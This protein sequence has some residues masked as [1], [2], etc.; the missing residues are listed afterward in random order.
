M[1]N[2]YGPDLHIHVHV[3]ACN[4]YCIH[5]C[6]QYMTECTMHIHMYMLTGKYG[7]QPGII[8]P[9]ERLTNDQ[10]KEEL[11][12]RELYD[13]GSTKA[14]TRQSLNEA[15]R[16]VQRVPSL[17]LNSPVENIRT[18]NLE[19]Y[20]ILECEPLHNLKGHL[21][22]VFAILPTILGKELAASCK[23][24]LNI[25]LFQK[26]TKRGFDCRLTAIHLLSLLK[27]SPATPNKVLQLIQ[28]I[29]IIS[30]ILYADDTKR[31]PQTVLKLY[32]S[33]FLHHEL[34]KELFNNTAAI[35]HRKLFGSHL[36]ALVVHAP[37]QYEIMSL[38]SCNAECEERLFGQAKAIA[39][40]TTNRQPNTIVPNILLRLQAKQK[41]GGM[42]ASM[43]G[44]S[45]KISKE[46]QGIREL[47]TDNTF[48]EKTFIDHR[49]ASWQA[50]LQRVSKFLLH[51]EGVWWK[52]RE[53]GYEFLDGFEAVN[54]TQG[55]MLLH[56]RETC[57]SDVQNQNEM[58]W[59]E[60]VAK[61]VPLPTPYIRRYDRNGEYCGRYLYNGATVE[62]QH[63]PSQHAPT[64]PHHAG[65]HHR[66]HSAYIYI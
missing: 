49:V 30:E 14:D 22:N 65:F 62:F 25:D 42:F 18:L 9:F 3:H 12:A 2:T 8:R 19:N 7:K 20:T 46:A 48:I 26:D 39:Q 54:Q 28:T 31:S 63:L 51:G 34:C 23:T 1:Y 66:K 13:F 55:P 47:T 24:L 33:T 38:R 21:S 35:S 56:Y 64:S 41:K 43:L 59:N 50:H 32:N 36:H 57:L 6:M 52:I 15:L 16:G 44:S 11:R 5:M 10:L 37:A 29:V 4:T 27:R 40:G 45:S 58:A 60:L 17:L 53:S 61:Q